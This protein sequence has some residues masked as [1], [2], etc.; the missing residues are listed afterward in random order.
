[1]ETS[2]PLIGRDA[3][4]RCFTT[5]LGWVA[6]DR[7][8]VL[9]VDGPPDSGRAR[10]LRECAAE[11]RRLGAAVAVT[12]ERVVV[13]RDHAGP[14]D[15]YAPGGLVAS[16]PVLIVA[17]S[18]A[19]LENVPAEVH[20]IRLGPLSPA[21]VRRLLAHA[22]PGTRPGPRLLDLTRVAAGRPGAVVRLIAGLREEGLLRIVDGSAVPLPGRLPDRTRARLAGRFA[23][24]SPAAR[25]LVQAATALPSPFPPARLAA[26]L[27]STVL[28]LLPA[29][30]EALD[31]GLLTAA[32]EA[33]SFSHDLVRPVVEAAM[34]CAVVAA[35]R[36][37]RGA[38]PRPAAARRGPRP[39]VSREADWS[40]L[41]G[42]E[43]EIAELVG[44]ALTN[45]QIADR[46]GLSPHT[47]NYHLRQ[48]FQ[49]LGLASRVELVSSLRRREAAAMR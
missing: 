20:R 24:L 30:E 39:A 23:A 40:A 28:G 22:L 2:L 16:A 13:V 36:S 29:I 11:G 48:I 49:K 33:L 19:G 27:G 43:M 37:E 25:H 14:V 26:L 3:E 46:V 47:V 12:R 8:A 42:R 45:R 35:L 21:D 7:A 15:A 4:M 31:S 38:R 34:P 17:T 5:L 18:A 6:P 10:L 32:G 44:Q 9:L 41:S 1:M